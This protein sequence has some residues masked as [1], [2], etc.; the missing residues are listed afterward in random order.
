MLYLFFDTETTGLIQSPLRPL[1]R[2]PHIIELFMIILD[3]EQNEV[4]RFHSLFKP[5]VPITPEIERITGISQHDLEGQP[6]FRDKLA[7]IITFMACADICI[8]HN[9]SYDRQMLEF[10]FKRCNGAIEFGEIFCTVEATEHIKGYRLNLQQ[11]HEY[12]FGQKF[13]N[14]HRAEN[15]VLA[16][17]RCFFE[18]QKRE[19]L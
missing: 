5:P 6:A 11:L 13:E 16:T 10:E 15:D 12:L 3:D 7:E 17:A 4:G 2:Q 9:A 19:L 14:A 1:D 18:L 8:A